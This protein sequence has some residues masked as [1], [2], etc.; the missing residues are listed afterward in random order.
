MRLVEKPFSL[1]FLFLSATSLAACGDPE[2]VNDSTGAGNAGG[3]GGNGGVGGTAGNGGDGNVLVGGGGGATT[4]TASND[5]CD[6]PRRDRH[7]RDNT[8]PPPHQPPC[9]P[10]EIRET[11]PNGG[12]I[13][14]D[15]LPT[16]SPLISLDGTDLRRRRVRHPPG[17]TE[18][19]GDDV[20]V[21]LPNGGERGGEAHL[22]E[23]RVLREHVHRATAWAL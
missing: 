20:L 16:S 23:R 10:T 4:T 15:L 22:R 9:S 8:C 17:A 12:A 7:L 6:P 13:C 3:S 19:L 2:I 1:V 5:P 14:T 18:C 11:G 21:C